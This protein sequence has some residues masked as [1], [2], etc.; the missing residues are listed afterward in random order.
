MLARTPERK[1]RWTRS[2]LLAAWFVLIASLFFDPLTPLLTSPDNLASPFHIGGSPVLVQGKPL[3]V[4]PY[5]M[6]NRIFWTM[7]LPLIPLVLMVFGHE[8]WRRV[9]PLSQFS[10]IPRMLGWQP[11]VKKLNRLTGKVERVLALLP[12]ESWLARNHYYVQFGLLAVGVAGR[13][14]FYN[15]DRVGLFAIFAIVLTSALAV[16]LLYGGKTWC[17]YFCPIAVIQDIYTGPGGLFDSKAHVA[18]S[19]ITQSMCRAPRGDTDQST[20]VGCTSNCPDV[21]LENSYWRN[22]DSNQKR[23]MYYAFFGVVFAFYTYYFVYAG[24]WDY[25]MTGAWTHEANAL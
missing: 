13:L 3:P 19:P 2:G 14:L 1:M 17:N 6:G 7:L 21:D 10:Q 5:A 20:C 18:P 8:T 4:E 16:G 15:S 22:V 23:F 25:Y 11:Q 12:S 24:N 9:C